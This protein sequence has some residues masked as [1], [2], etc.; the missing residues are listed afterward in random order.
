MLVRKYIASTIG[1]ASRRA[2][3]TP[4]RWLLLVSAL[5]PLALIALLAA[6]RLL[7]GSPLYHAIR[8]RAAYLGLGWCY[9]VLPPRVRY[10]F[11]Q[12][13]AWEGDALF[14]ENFPCARSEYRVWAPEG[15]AA[16]LPTGGATNLIVT[17]FFDIGREHW[18]YYARSN[19]EYMAN[20]KNT[21]SLRNP[22][23]FFTT[24]DKAEGVVEARRKAGLMDRTMVVAHDLHCASQAWMLPGVLDSM[25]S[26]STIAR[27]WAFNPN[28]EAPERQEPWYNLIMWMKAG[29]VR[30][31]AALPHPALAAQWVTWLD[32][33]CHTPACDAAW[34]RGIYFSPARWARADRVRISHMDEESDALARMTPAEW[35]REHRV[36][37]M[38]TVFGMT[39]AR[40]RFLMDAFLDTAQWMLV[41]GVVDTDQ[42]IFAW[43]W[44]A[45]PEYF[46]VYPSYGDYQSKLGTS[47]RAFAGL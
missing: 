41:R 10:N 28:L 9:P 8:S 16:P 39:R 3:L 46:D 6:V 20:I 7:P 24:P 18:P 33:G 27:M 11:S 13:E 25:C 34:I 14:W 2:A 37:F 44:R 35:T 22:M 43:M 36:L 4:K 40:A 17:A 38:G 32:A 5:I 15:A 12:P 47:V 29:V 23:V 31:A 45:N 21:L 26:A 42:T 1:F 30:A 19:E